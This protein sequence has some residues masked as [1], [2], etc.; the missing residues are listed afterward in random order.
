[1]EV[2]A[3]RSKWW[4]NKSSNVWVSLERVKKADYILR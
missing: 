4:R 1:M 3:K 2:E